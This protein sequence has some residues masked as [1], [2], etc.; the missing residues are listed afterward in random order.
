M[1]VFMHRFQ[2]QQLTL[3]NTIAMIKVQKEMLLSP[4][5]NMYKKKP[6]IKLAF[7]LT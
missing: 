5:P 4:P 3:E 7:F 2:D 1:R 6:V